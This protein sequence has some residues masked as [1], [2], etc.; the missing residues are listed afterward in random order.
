MKTKYLN[1][2]K[3]I[4]SNFKY[5]IINKLNCLT[6]TISLSISFD[7]LINLSQKYDNLLLDN[8]S[9]YWSLYWSLSSTSFKLFNNDNEEIKHLY[10]NDKDKIFRLEICNFQCKIYLFNNKSELL[11]YLTNKDDILELIYQAY[12]LHSSISKDAMIFIKEDDLWIDCSKNLIELLNLDEKNKNVYN[13]I[14]NFK[15]KKS[16]YLACLLELNEKF[17][18]ELKLIQKA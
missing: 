18:T 6:N 4:F 8:R 9:N 15:N 13:F 2:Y 11:N 1:L 12:A 7:Q 16:E 10:E 5:E 14:I 17:K 3:E